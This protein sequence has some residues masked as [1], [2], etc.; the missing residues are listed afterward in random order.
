VIALGEIRVL[1]FLCKIGDLGGNLIL[2]IWE[3]VLE[4][5]KVKALT[6]LRIKFS[7]LLK[8]DFVA[9]ENP[10]K[11]Y[12]KKL[13]VENIHTLCSRQRQNKL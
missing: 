13:E 5:W 3:K 1:L 8:L 4:I 12:F 9:L 11:E 6:N 2:V 10:I 7:R